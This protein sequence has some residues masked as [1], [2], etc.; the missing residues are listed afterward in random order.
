[1]VRGVSFSVERGETFA[2]VGESGSGKSTLARAI[3]GV[4]APAHGQ[5]RFAGRPLPDTVRARSDAV[6]QQ[7]QYIFQNPD[8][9]LNP[10][11]TVGDTVGRP[12]EVFSSCAGPRSQERI[13]A[14]LEDVR[15]DASYAERYPDQLSGGERQRVAIARAL[16]PAT[17]A[18]CCATKSCPPSTS[19]CRPAS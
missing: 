1:M 11:R 9:S 19:R 6:R 13:A 12:L 3:S 2:L 10:R 7:I 5:I 17:P 4:L 14:L 18:S 15:L 8:A 16:W